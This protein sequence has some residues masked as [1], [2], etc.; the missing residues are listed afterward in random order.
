MH[1]HIVTYLNTPAKLNLSLYFVLFFETAL[2][3]TMPAYVVGIND[4]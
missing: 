4:F 3:S 2:I 1:S